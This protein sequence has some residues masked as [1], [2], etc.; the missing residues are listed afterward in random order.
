MKTK[1]GSCYQSALFSL[2]Q[3]HNEKKGVTLDFSFKFTLKPES[4]SQKFCIIK[5]N[6]Q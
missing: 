3:V 1:K 2:T 6:I 4:E 5:V